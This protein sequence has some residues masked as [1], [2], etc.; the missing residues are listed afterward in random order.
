MTPGF[1]RFLGLLARQIASHA[2]PGR[3][4]ETSGSD[5]WARNALPARRLAFAVTGRS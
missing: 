4:A 3:K 1:R 5:S 2:M